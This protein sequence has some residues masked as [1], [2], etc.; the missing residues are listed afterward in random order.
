MGR[1][2]LPESEPRHD[3]LCH[4]RSHYTQY[5]DKARRHE[6]PQKTDASKVSPPGGERVDET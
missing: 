1:W 5:S 4:R 3:G 2:L 6:A